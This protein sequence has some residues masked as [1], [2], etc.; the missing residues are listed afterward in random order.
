MP[1]PKKKRTRSAKNIKK[2]CYWTKIKSPS[3]TLCSQCK[4]PIRAH[5]VCPYCGTYKG[6]QV[7]DIEAKEKKKEEKRKH[8]E[9]EAKKEATQEQQVEKPEGK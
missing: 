2:A 9:E 5:Q 4:K 1:V 7:I 6:V 8:R 3:L